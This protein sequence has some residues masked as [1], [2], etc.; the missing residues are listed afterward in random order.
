MPNRT[1]GGLNANGIG[2]G[3]NEIVGVVAVTVGGKI[4]GSNPR[5][6]CRQRPAWRIVTKVRFL[7]DV[8]AAVGERG[9]VRMIN[10]IS[11]DGRVMGIVRARVR[12]VDICESKTAGV[13][14]I[15]TAHLAVFNLVRQIA[16]GWV[17]KELCGRDA[18][19]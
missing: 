14:R 10:N 16:V 1:D 12:R 11:A 5:Q 17:V 7:N 8:V 4:A 6:F 2:L 3:A 18:I 13:G 19:G 9:F 15:E